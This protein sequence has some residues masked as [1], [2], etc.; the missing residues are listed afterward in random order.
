MKNSNGINYKKGDRKG[1]S[2]PEI[3][4][5]KIIAQIESE[6][7]IPGQKLPPQNELAKVFGVGTSS[8]REAINALQIMGYVEVAHG[9]GMF[10]REELPLNQTIISTME[11]DLANASPYELF[12][13]RELIECHMVKI[14]CQQ[15]DS[16]GIRRLKQ[17]VEKMRAGVDEKKEY[18]DADLEF[19]VAIGNTVGFRAAGAMIRML[20]EMM[21]K[22]LD[23]AVYSQ[24]SQYRKDATDSVEEVL[25]HIIEGEEF[26]AVR[27]MRNHLNLPRRAVATKTNRD[28]YITGE[29]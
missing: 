17:I 21:H 5:N 8:V 23:L 26:H 12:E 16:K 1:Q 11:D 6:E 24:T 10:V 15:I 29:D 27:C 18:I 22:N 14:A 3:V 9:R 2:T 4:A 20:H 19:H 25:E 28:K 7:L 13:L